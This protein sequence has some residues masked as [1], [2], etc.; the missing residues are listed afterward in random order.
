M[1][2]IIITTH[3]ERPRLSYAQARACDDN[4]AA[5]EN[6]DNADTNLLL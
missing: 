4:A 2:I 6:N 3:A 5:T 1:L